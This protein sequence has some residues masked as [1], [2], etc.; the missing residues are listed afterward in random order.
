MERYFACLAAGATLASTVL[1]GS[2][3]LA[4]AGPPPASAPGTLLVAAGT[5]EKG[6]SGDGGPATRAQLG[7][8]IGLAVDAT[9]NLFIAD[10]GNRRIRKVSPDGIITTVAGNGTSGSA[11]DG[12]P[13]V[14]AQ[15]NNPFGLAV[16][17]VAAPGLAAGQPFPVR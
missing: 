5:G 1:S 16:V 15:F 12:G 3:S 4:A 10:S 9:G 11:G 14:Q 7:T 17:G 13:A 6:F 2:A 8:P